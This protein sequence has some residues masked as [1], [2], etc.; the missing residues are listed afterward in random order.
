MPRN[1]MFDT[2]I[3]NEILDGRINID[4]LESEENDYLVTHVQMDE[5][6]KCPDEER[7]KELLRIFSQ[8]NQKEIST[9]SGVFDTSRFNK[10][11][12]GEGELLE[13]IRKGNI[14]HTEDALIGETAIKNGCIL[15]TNDKRLLNKVNEL[16]GAALDFDAF[17]L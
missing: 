2:N 15:V 16:G 9:E 1:I 17:S 7:R 13:E 3:F 6:K 14:K 10:A 8:I 12:F 5:L 4:D 11:K